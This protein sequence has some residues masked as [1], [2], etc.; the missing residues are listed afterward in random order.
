MI[1]RI[2]FIV[3]CALFFLLVAAIF[4]EFS[5]A[6]DY[7]ISSNSTSTNGGNTINGSDSLTLESGISITV[8]GTNNRGIT[9]T[10]DDNTLYVLGTV[11]TNGAG[12]Y[13]IFLNASDNNTIT[14]FNHIQ[15]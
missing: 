7:T 11:T 1:K 9:F 12:G 15:T 10:G 2:I 8:S 6:D 3:F 4:S 5:R 13:G 14:I